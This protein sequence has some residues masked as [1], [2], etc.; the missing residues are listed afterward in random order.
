VEVSARREREPDRADFLQEVATERV[1]GRIA[2][3]L[4]GDP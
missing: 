2:G 1:R 3:R 4:D